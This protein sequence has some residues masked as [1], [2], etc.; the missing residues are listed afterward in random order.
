[1]CIFTNTT[2][3]DCA[4]LFSCGKLNS[5]VRWAFVE[6]H[7]GTP[8][9]PHQHAAQ[10]GHLGAHKALSGAR[11]ARH[12]P[13]LQV[14]PVQE[15]AAGANTAKGYGARARTLKPQ[16]CECIIKKDNVNYV[17]FGSFWQKK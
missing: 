15:A 1:M 7:C 3:L 2:R 9:P 12:V 14:Q 5:A 8:R 10:P 17:C 11:P 13:L 4:K 6:R 16:N